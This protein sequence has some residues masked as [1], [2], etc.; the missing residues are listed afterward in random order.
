[1]SRDAPQETPLTS[2]FFS[3]NWNDRSLIV[4]A[5]LFLLLGV[6]AV[7]SAATP[8]D[9]RAD[10]EDE[11]AVRAPLELWVSLELPP[12]PY[13]STTEDYLDSELLLFRLPEAI[14]ET[15]DL[16]IALDPVLSFTLASDLDTELAR[17]DS[18]DGETYFS[19]GLKLRL[20]PNL[21]LFVEDFM[22]STAVLG[23]DDEEWI[24]RPSWDGHQVAL[25]VL[26]QPHEQLSL[27][28]E[29]I[30]FLLSETRRDPD[31]GWAA[32]LTWK[33]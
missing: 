10:Y 8:S 7:A 32:S 29:V 17:L 24:S 13:R 22:S 20:T 16:E 12:V 23:R 9:L 11:G 1:M 30:G 26:A 3:H 6:P 5:L 21:S 19:A 14:P 25:G 4:P 18:V 28:G 27:R 33:F 31:V 2:P 15:L